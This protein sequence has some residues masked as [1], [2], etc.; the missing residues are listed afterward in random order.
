MNIVWFK[1]DLRLR[2]HDPLAEA[3]ALGK[4][5]LLLYCFEPSLIAA[6]DT[7]TRHFRFAYECLVDMRTALAKEGQEIHIVCGEVLDILSSINE[8]YSIANLFSY[9]EVGTKLTFDRD[10]NVKK[11]CLEKEIAF[12]S[13]AQNGTVRGKKNR[14]DW[15]AQL[16]AGYFSYPVTKVDLSKLVNLK[17]GAELKSIFDKEPIPTEFQESKTGFQKG[18]ESYAWKYYKSFL[19]KRVWNYSRHISK[20]ELSRK[21]CSRLSPYLAF[22]CISAKAVMQY[23]FAQSKKTG[24]EW[25][26][27]NFKSRIWWRSHYIQKLET[28]WQIES[29]PI[30]RA[31]NE[32]DRA[33]GG[34]LFEAWANG[35]TGYPMVDACMKCLEETGWI[36]FRMRGMLVTFASY[37]LW[38][39]WRQL[40]THLAKLF[41]DYDPGIHYPQIQMQAG[42][43]GYHTL[44][45]FNP[46]AQVE[47]HDSEG[48]FIKR[49]LPELIDVPPSHLI[50]PWKMT[51][52][53]QTF[54][55]C[56]IGEDYPSPIVDYGLATSENKDRYW[57]TRQSLEAKKN[58]PSIWEKY[59]VPSDAEKYK[60]QLKLKD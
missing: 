19:Q 2:D 54:Y 55:N 45:I 28:D 30:N 27:S 7:S 24:E 49:W 13:F 56:K 9:E 23:A 25:N 31:F 34:K 36:N 22:G 18:G 35:K 40:A 8:F 3:I 58:L 41:L 16:E 29:Q 5:V 53:E 20:P 12:K 44:R 37:A 14:A 50:E 51:Q 57:A 6:E 59:C 38:L 26:F 52:M 60:L 39:D 11:W 43:S 15:Q 46:M 17:I 10:R 47:K 21:S 1:K 32:L 42:L 4:P 33:V 48:V